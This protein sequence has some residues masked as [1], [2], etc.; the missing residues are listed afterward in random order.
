M[1]EEWQVEIL[2]FTGQGN[3]VLKSIDHLLDGH[4]QHI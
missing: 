2:Y 3:E 4:N 1:C